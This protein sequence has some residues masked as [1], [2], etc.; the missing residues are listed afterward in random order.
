MTLRRTS[1]GLSHL[2]APQVKDKVG[3]VCLTCN[4]ILDFEGVVEG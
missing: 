2:L 1:T 4:R 3:G